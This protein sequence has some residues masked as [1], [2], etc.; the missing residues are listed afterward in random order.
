VSAEVVDFM[1]LKPQRRRLNVHLDAP[2]LV[3]FN[4]ARIMLDR[5]VAAFDLEPASFCGA[6]PPT[7]MATYRRLCPS[8]PVWDGGPGLHNL[9]RRGRDRDVRNVC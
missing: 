7:Y 9:G 1:G 8:M 4:E 3:A 6:G 5:Q 2:V